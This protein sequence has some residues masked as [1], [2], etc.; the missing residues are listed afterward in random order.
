MP[1]AQILTNYSVTC[2][3]AGVSGKL[4]VTPYPPA[5]QQELLGFG[6]LRTLQFYYFTMR[7]QG[8]TGS[9]TI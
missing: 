2:Q 6:L 9:R 3:K 4:L 7:A 5:G 8:Y 1:L